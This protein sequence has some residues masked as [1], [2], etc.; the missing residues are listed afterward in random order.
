MNTQKNIYD[1]FRIILGI[2]FLFSGIG[3]FYGDSFIIGPGYIFE[4]LSKHNLLYF[5]MFIALSQITIGFLLLIRKFSTLGAIMLLPMILNILIVTISLKWQGTPIVVC[6]F[7]LMNLFL[8]FH[9]RS[10]FY[11]IF[12]FNN[13][14]EFLI[15]FKSTA[16]YILGFIFVLSGVLLYYFLNN[17]FFKNIQKIGL[18]IIILNAIYRFYLIRKRKL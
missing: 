17:D 12:G 11:S 4:E 9:K 16:I 15:F 7:L 10:K 5:A 3:K 13:F 2:T 14:R 6:I 18:L 1:I 8:L